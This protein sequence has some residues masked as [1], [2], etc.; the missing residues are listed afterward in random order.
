MP[1]TDDYR[2]KAIEGLTEAERTSDQ[3][4]RDLLLTLAMAYARLAEIPEQNARTDLVYETRPPTRLFY[5]TDS[6]SAR[7]CTPKMS[8]ARTGPCDQ[9]GVATTWIFVHAASGRQC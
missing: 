9:S 4:V 5:F 8:A 1:S 7:S 3:R 2:A 6:L